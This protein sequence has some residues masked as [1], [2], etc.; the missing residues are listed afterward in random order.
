MKR[1]L[2]FILLLMLI[3]TG[4]VCANDG[5]YFANGSQL[6][7]IRE[8]DISVSREVLTISLCDDGFARIEVDYEFLNHGAAKTVQMGFEAMKPYNTADTLNPAGIHPYIKD[9]TVMMNGRQ[10]AYHNAVVEPGELDTPYTGPKDDRPEEFEQYAYAYCFEA[11][12]R[13][14]VNHVHH[15]YRYQMSYGV[16]RTFEVPYWLKPAA[17]WQGGTIGDF[18]LRIRTPR[19]AKHFI[20]ADSLFTDHE[21]VVT[22]G[23][24]KV[25]HSKYGWSPRLVEVAL[26]DGT[27]EWHSRDFR[28]VDNICIQSADTYTSFNKK[29]P[30]GTFYDRSESYMNWQPEQD[31]PEWLARN[32]PYANRGYVFKKK[33]LRKH[34]SQF[35][36]YMPDEKYR[37]STDD[38]TPREWRLIRE[39][40]LGL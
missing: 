1:Y 18:T 40:K 6:V 35:W 33:A 10:L 32:L 24:G 8:T 5:V 28:P 3:G 9:F 4:F 38:F 11:T 13:E 21:F 17:R 31:F 23:T 20:I 16:G 25:R 15:T 14:G 26:R 12:F 19:T 7:P 36:W 27:V 2:F 37:P 30:L 29:Y 34:F 22:E 39:H